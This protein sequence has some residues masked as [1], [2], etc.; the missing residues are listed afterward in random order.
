MNEK[1]KEILGD[2]FDASKLESLDSY[3]TKGIQSEADRV[4]TKYSTENKELSEKLKTKEMENMSELERR[5]ALFNEERQ[6]FADG[7]KT[8]E[9]DRLIKEKT[10]FFKEKGASLDI[11][12]LVNGSNN[13]EWSKSL[14]NIHNI[15]NK[16][17]ETRIK[18]ESG[19]EAIGGNKQP[20]EV[21]VDQAA[22]DAF[23][24]AFK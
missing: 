8:W 7:K 17:V 22:L 3:F 19:R 6:S 5:E 4:R 1:L 9:K 13:E 10:D 14:E 2:D 21:N 20:Q 18:G 23:D 16:N 15:I 11:F 12:D 24:K